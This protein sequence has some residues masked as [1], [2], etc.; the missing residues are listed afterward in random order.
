MGENQ[1]QSYVRVMAFTW[2]DGKLLEKAWVTWEELRRGFATQFGQMPLM[3]YSG[4][5][6]PRQLDAT[7]S[8]T[9]TKDGPYKDEWLSDVV[10]EYAYQGAETLAGNNSKLRR[11][12]ID[13]TP[14]IF[15]QQLETGKYLP[16]YPVYV[17]NDDSS[18]RLFTIS[19]EMAMKTNPYEGSG[20]V[21]EKQYKEQITRSRL[22]QPRF[23]AEV[24]LAYNTACAI[25]RIRH[26]ELLDA[27]H[28]IPDSMPSG[29]AAVRNGMSLCKIHHAAFDK[30]LLGISPDLK[31]HIRPDL[32]LEV[33]GPMLRSGIQEMSGVTISTPEKRELAPDKDG[34][35][36]KFEIFKN[37]QR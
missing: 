25:C 10:F 7:L 33:D 23:R 3:N 29:I 17:K 8:I 36:W 35:S 28:I 1:D 12:M 30:N 5:W 11:A 22:H 26:V 37:Y 24:L 21:M 18:R 14:L 6:N 34:L 20:L 31:V 19:L 4:I 27:A 15:F 16:I 2:L 32:M 13:A 9:S